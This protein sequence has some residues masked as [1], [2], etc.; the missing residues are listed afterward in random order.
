MLADRSKPLMIYGA[1]L[2]VLGLASVLFSPE[3]GIG[4]NTKGISGLIA[5]VAGG[6]LAVTF[7]ALARSGRKWAVTAGLILAFAF[8]VMSSHR[9]I[10]GWRDVNAGAGKRYAAVLS[11]LMAVASLITAV[12]TARGLGSARIESKPEPPKP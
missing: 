11:S 7:G 6:G 5:G 1:A 12:S 4:F 3:M 8:L 9:A 2:I 10:L